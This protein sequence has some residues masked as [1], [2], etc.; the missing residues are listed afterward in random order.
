[1][2]KH[3][4]A[5]LI[6]LT[7]ILALISIFFIASISLI[8]KQVILWPNATQAPRFGAFLDDFWK[9]MISISETGIRIKRSLS[10]IVN[11]LARVLLS[12]SHTVTRISIFNNLFNWYIVPSSLSLHSFLLFLF[13]LGPLVE[14]IRFNRPPDVSSKETL[15][16]IIIILP[17][18]DFFRT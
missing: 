14:K 6:N 8:V 12:K 10:I 9:T 16:S 11:C 5:A 4:F 3:L 1:M 17:G 18:R 2:S 7:M 15:D 13:L